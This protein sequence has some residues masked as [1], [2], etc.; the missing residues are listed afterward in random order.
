[1]CHEHLVIPARRLTSLLE[2]SS[3]DLVSKRKTLGSTGRSLRAL[4]RQDY[5]KRWG[6]LMNGRGEEKVSQLLL[7]YRGQIEDER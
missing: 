4:I 6:V 5:L 2:T 1:V 7:R 3:A